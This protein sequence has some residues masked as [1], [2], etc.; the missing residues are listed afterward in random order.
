MAMRPPY[1]GTLLQLVSHFQATLV[2]RL[3]PTG[4]AVDTVQPHGSEKGEE[5][6]V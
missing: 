5:A 2:Y 4:E 3:I 6:T 1:K